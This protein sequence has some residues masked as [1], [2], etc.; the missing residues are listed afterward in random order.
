MKTFKS[1]SGPLAERP[2]YELAEIE[3]ICTGELK[4]YGL[5]PSEP[6]P[7]RIDR[8]IEKRFAVQPTYDD[9]PKGLLG[10]TRF[11]AKGV[12]EI[13]VARFLDEEGTTVAD[14]R[15]RTTLAHEGGH[16]LL[17]AHLFA[18]ETLPTA[19]FGDGLAP[20]TPKILCRDE[21][22]PGGQPSRSKTP[23]RWWEFQANQAMGALLL[24]RALVDTA[25]A[26]F[27]E[28]QGR[29]RL[30]GI[31]ELRR[32]DAVRHLAETFDLNPVVARIRL[33]GIHPRSDGQL[34][35]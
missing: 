10:F 21:A 18:L 5:Y 16:G 31:P 24:P 23:T 30:P 26:A 7:I 35:L 3:K 13:V 15:V 14:R 33:D 6:G 25:L 28:P 17:H 11:G 34:T 9:L 32:E 2:F 4:K 8:F 22:S 29:L 20:G 1:R 19:L 27:L 12:E